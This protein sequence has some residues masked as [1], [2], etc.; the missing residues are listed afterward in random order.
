MTETMSN[1]STVTREAIMPG[2]ARAE[3]G[4]EDPET[5]MTEGADR[6]EE[7]LQED[8]G[9]EM[10]T[11]DRGST[12][13][14]ALTEAV[15]AIVT[16]ITDLVTIEEIV[17]VTTAEEEMTLAMVAGTVIAETDREETQ[18]ACPRKDTA[19]KRIEATPTKREVPQTQERREETTDLAAEFNL[20][21]DL[22]KA[23]TTEGMTSLKR[24]LREEDH[25]HI[26]PLTTIS[27]KSLKRLQKSQKMDMLRMLRQSEVIFNQQNA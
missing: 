22:T 5:G 3:R 7:D 16:A 24:S 20:R 25:P 11:T 4:R 21:E 23:P 9:I 18:D 12:I 13:E 27:T 2:T 1:A 15:T 14:N 19:E 10:T 17:T 8:L 6:P 26:E